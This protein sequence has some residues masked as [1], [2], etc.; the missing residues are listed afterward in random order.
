M[1]K[2][3]KREQQSTTV[4]LK[5]GLVIATH[6]ATVEVEDDKKHLHPCISRKKVGVAVCGDHV[7]WHAEPKQTGL[8]HEILPRTNLLV[9][10]DARNKLKPIASNIDY[11]CITLAPTPTAIDDNETTLNQTENISLFDYHAIDRYI[12]AAE[13]SRIQALIIIN[14]VDLLNETML[15]DIQSKL[16]HYDKLNYHYVLTSPKTNLGIKTLYR[17]IQNRTCVFVGQSGV[18]KSSLIRCFVD[19]DDIS[20]GSIS[21]VTGQGRHT[22]TATRMYH[23]Q[24]GGHIID[25]PGV[26]E[27]GLWNIE[28]DEIMHTFRE[29][30]PYIGSCKFNNCM[31]TSEP[32]CAVK[33]ALHEKKIRAERYDAYLKIL[34]SLN[35][36]R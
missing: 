6:G 18:G 19:D 17:F 16:D 20:I 34:A 25:S 30:T 15:A 32:G 1:S 8:I 23:L 7:K 9:R 2:R 36:P 31:H 28:A 4:T 35:D 33:A 27:F 22:T 29:F 24:N 12:V 10:P 11:L 14:K 3:Y 26:R 13:A 5:P 21:K